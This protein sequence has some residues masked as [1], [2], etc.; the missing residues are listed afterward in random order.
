MT[1]EARAAR[2]RRLFTAGL[3]A[4]VTLTAGG[5]AFVSLN[6]SHG[7]LDANTLSVRA[8]RGLDATRVRVF[9]GPGLLLPGDDPASIARLRA[10]PLIFDGHRRGPFAPGAGAWDFLVLYEH[11]YALFRHVKTR[12]QDQHDY[13][14]RLSWEGKE[15]Y[16]EVVIEGADA[17]RMEVPLRPLR[18]TG[19]ER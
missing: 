10:A 15:P 16:L 11:R 17:A 19:T 12:A 2:S 1:P 18:G 13:R 14:L 8:D 6:R 5:V 4:A 3:L 7:W 9:S